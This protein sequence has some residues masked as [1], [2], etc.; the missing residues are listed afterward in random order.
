MAPVSA[1]PHSLVLMRGSLLRPQGW[2]HPRRSRRGPPFHDPIRLRMGVGGLL[3]ERC[4]PPRE[5][6]GPCTFLMLFLSSRFPWTTSLVTEHFGATRP[7]VTRL[8]VPG[9]DPPLRQSWSAETDRARGIARR[10]PP[11]RARGAP[12]PRQPGPQA[13]AG[14]EFARGL[15]EGCIL[16]RRLTERRSLRPSRRADCAFWSRH[17]PG[18]VGRDPP[19]AC[20][21]LWEVAQLGKR[22]RATPRQ[23]GGGVAP[24][25]AGSGLGPAARKGAIWAEGLADGTPWVRPGHHRAASGG[26][27][28]CQGLRVTFLG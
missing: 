18:G 25:P 26:L 22:A 7:R 14:V 27:R 8:R 28:R 1:V 2:G 15:A 4:R 20:G 10:N 24:G 9:P 16:A 6:Q 23:A 19:P 3:G 13:C 5:R 21:A 11:A 12:E 17:R